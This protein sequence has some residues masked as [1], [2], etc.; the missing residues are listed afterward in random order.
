MRFTFPENPL[1]LESVRLVVAEEPC[2]TVNEIGFATIVKP[3]GGGDVT[4]RKTCTECASFP[5]DPVRFIM[6]VPIGV[7]GGTHTVNVELPVP[8]SKERELGFATTVMLVVAGGVAFRFT[9]PENP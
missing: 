5:L 7:E 6:N 2:E 3:G 9:L 4:S 1:T 8:V